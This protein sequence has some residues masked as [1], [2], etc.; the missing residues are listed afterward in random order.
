M[1]PTDNEQPKKR[2]Q[3]REKFDPRFVF[4]TIEGAFN[5]NEELMLVVDPAYSAKANRSLNLHPDGKDTIFAYNTYDFL[6]LG[7]VEP[8]YWRFSMRFEGAGDNAMIVFRKKKLAFTT[9]GRWYRT[10]I[11]FYVDDR[12]NNRIKPGSKDHHLDYHDLDFSD[13]MGHRLAHAE[14]KEDE[15]ESNSLTAPAQALLVSEVET[16]TDSTL[17][18]LHTPPKSPEHP[19]T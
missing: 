2:K 18:S 1:D 6:Y 10:C 15:Q 17:T 4:R 8:G 7:R 13:H 5:G 16:D 9:Y 12:D 3:C 11:P 19:A 14:P